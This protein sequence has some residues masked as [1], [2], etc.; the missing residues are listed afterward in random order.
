MDMIKLYENVRYCLRCGSPLNIQHD[1]EGKLRPQCP[2]CGWIY[3]LNPV[4]AVAIVVINERNE[5]LLIKRRFDPKAGMWALPSGYMEIN[6]SPEENAIAELQE[7]TGLEGEIDHCIGWHYGHS[8]IYH[9]ILS[10]G[11]RMQATGGVL[12]AGDD[13]MEAEFYPIDKV[14]P[15]AFQSHR[16]FISIEMKLPRHYL[17]APAGE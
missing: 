11:F 8:P 1:R 10:I 6:M 16:K 12:C 14:P 5:L 9:K 3:Y 7:E 15:I 2:A 13:A 4:P 17:K